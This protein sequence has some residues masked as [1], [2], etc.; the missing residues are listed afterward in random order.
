MDAI[1]TLKTALSTVTGQLSKLKDELVDTDR[2]IGIINA[3]IEELH[4]MPI[5]LED[6][7]VF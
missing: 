5:S 2:Q 7:G 3:Q 6:W 4:D 1:K